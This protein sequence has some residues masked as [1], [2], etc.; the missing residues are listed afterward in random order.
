MHNRCA[1]AFTGSHLCHAAEYISSNSLATVPAGGAWLDASLD[2]TGSITVGAG[3]LFG[4]SV[5]YAGSCDSWTNAT[6]AYLGAR[7]SENGAVLQNYDC[8]TF[9][10]LACCN[11][12]AKTSFAGFT[13]FAT[14]GAIAQGRIGMH[15]ACNT[16]FAGSHMCH[17]AEYIRTSSLAAPPAVGA[18]LDA[19]LDGSGAISVGG[20]PLAGRSISY[21]GSCDAWTNATS[22]YLGARV[23]SN[24]AILQNYDCATVRPIACCR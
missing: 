6:T 4:R 12:V 1:A 17:A 22:A 8:A 11:G 21:A 24:G 10:P 19:S 18:W 15:K 20:L 3:P 13:A 2:L 23:S 14:P 9:R 7:A 5:S 16:E